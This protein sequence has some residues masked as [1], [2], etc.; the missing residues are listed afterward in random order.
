MTCAIDFFGP[1]IHADQPVRLRNGSGFSSTPLTTL[2]IAVL[3]PMPERER[4]DRDHREPGLRDEPPA[5]VA[6]VLPEVGDHE[7]PASLVSCAFVQ[8]LGPPI[9]VRADVGSIGLPERV[10]R[11]V[12]SPGICDAGVSVGVGLGHA[13]G[14]RV[15]VEV[16]ELRRELAHDARFALAREV[17]QRQTV[18]DV[19]FQSRTEAS[20]LL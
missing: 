7:P 3:A 12:A 20:I 6:N 2:K 19:L 14:N 10:P 4:Q 16:F 5:R 15:A 17:R 18:A 13:A 8:A 1:V 11:D 9:D